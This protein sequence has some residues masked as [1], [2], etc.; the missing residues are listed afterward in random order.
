M[1]NALVTIA[2][3]VP[4]LSGTVDQLLSELDAGRAT[5]AT[6]LVLL[7]GLD[8]SGVDLPA[9]VTAALDSLSTFC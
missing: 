6:T 2:K 8:E 1:S 3:L 7:M 5:P 9:E 4:S